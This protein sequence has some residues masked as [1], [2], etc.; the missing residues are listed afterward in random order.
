MKGRYIIL[1]ASGL[2]LAYKIGKMAGHSDCMIEVLK[3]QKDENTIA[4]GSLV[5]NIGKNATLTITKSTKE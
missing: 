4:E 1:V 5:Y 2:Y 3:Q